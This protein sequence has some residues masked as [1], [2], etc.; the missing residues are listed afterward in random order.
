MIT[1]CKDITLMRAEVYK[2]RMV[3]YIAYI[4]EFL[5]LYISSRYGKL[6]FLRKVL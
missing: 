3:F 2:E 4:I 1:A 5:E 6:S